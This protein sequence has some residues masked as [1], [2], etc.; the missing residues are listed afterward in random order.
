MD[1]KEKNANI[2][3]ID[4]EAGIGDILK[5]I[6]VKEGHN[7]IATT[8]GR[9]GIKCIKKDAISLVIL[10]IKMAEID[11]IEVLKKIHEID[12]DI[13][14]I[15]LTAYATLGTAREAM[16]LGAYDYI[17][18]PFDNEFVKAMVKEGLKSAGGSR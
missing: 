7:V 15:M 5:K 10:D 18:K 8:S 17:T 13:V 3:V 11:G 2:L 4:D 16:R 9:E 6:L 14:V 12:K 1:S